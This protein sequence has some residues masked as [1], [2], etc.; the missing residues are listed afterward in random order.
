MND[1]IK[2]ELMMMTFPDAETAMNVVLF[3]EAGEK[4][5]CDAMPLIRERFQG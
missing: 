2:R 1:D 5:G 3:L 4:I